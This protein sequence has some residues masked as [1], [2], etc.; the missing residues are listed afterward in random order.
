M[1]EQSVSNAQLGKIPQVMVTSLNSRA[2]V[3]NDTLF[4]YLTLLLAM[5]TMLCS[6]NFIN[7]A[8]SLS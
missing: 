6:L 1:A 4:M 8:R 2:M 7:N 5:P 3:I